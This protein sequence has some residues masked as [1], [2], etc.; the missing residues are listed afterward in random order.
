MCNANCWADSHP[1]SQAAM[2]PIRLAIGSLSRTVSKQASRHA[3]D[4]VAMNVGSNLGRRS[5]Q[6][7]AEAACERVASLSNMHQTAH[8]YPNFTC[9]LCLASG[10]TK[11]SAYQPH[12]P[13]NPSS[14]SRVLLRSK[15]ASARWLRRWPSIVMSQ[16]V[17]AIWLS[18]S[19]F[20]VPLPPELEINRKDK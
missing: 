9:C 13:A 4:R 20:L 8:R 12:F 16:P 1:C 15:W 17:L 3:A 11:H 7:V 2:Q 5:I 14:S 18:L 19:G 10:R 6:H